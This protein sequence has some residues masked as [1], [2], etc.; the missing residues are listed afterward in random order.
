M[1]FVLFPSPRQLMPN[2]AAFWLLMQVGMM[3]GFCTSWPANVWLV[4]RGVKVPM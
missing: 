1:A 2:T 4:R 3:I